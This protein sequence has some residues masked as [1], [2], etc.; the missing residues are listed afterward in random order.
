[1]RHLT[2]TL[3][4]S[5]LISSTLTTHAFDLQGCL[6][7][8][9]SWL[10][11]LNSATQ[12]EIPVASAASPNHKYTLSARQVQE[13]LD[14]YFATLEYGL[15]PAATHSDISAIRAITANKIE[16]DRS[17]YIW[18]S[19]VRFYNKDMIDQYSLEAIVEYIE[20]SSYNLAYN[21]V[22]NGAT[23][24]K[25]SLSIKASAQATINNMSYLDLSQIQKFFGAAL[26]QLVR[27][28]INQIDTP[29]QPSY[30]PQAQPTTNSQSLYPSTSCCICLEDFGAVTNKR[31][32][33]KPCGHDICKLCALNYFFPADMPDRTRKCPHCRS[34]VNFDALFNDLE[35]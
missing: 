35:L 25:V 12:Q 13:Y 27:Q 34:N 24:N 21:Q 29:Y 14:N 33:L 28:R 20:N 22:F 17:I 30:T 9:T 19:G 11:S 5:L 32:Y 6:E 15:Y 23:A 31:I 1:M 7:Q 26:S 16:T 2:T 8:L 3:I 18:V 4:G 10:Q